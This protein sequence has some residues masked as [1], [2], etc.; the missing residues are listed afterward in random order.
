MNV[1]VGRG[2]S[3]LFI[4]LSGRC[5]FCLDSNLFLFPFQENFLVVSYYH[6]PIIR[7]LWRGEDKRKRKRLDC[8]V[9]SL[10]FAVGWS[11]HRDRSVDRASFDIK[12]P[13]LFIFWFKNLP[14]RFLVWRADLPSAAIKSAPRLSL[15]PQTNQ[16][17]FSLC[18]MRFVSPPSA[19]RVAVIHIEW[20]VSGARFVFPLQQI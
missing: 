12:F 16:L 9:E 20:C 13:L 19:Q 17:L 8:W 4:F 18:L 14:I 10:L 5:P 6:Q 3:L 7:L 2:N 11:C 1:S 15:K